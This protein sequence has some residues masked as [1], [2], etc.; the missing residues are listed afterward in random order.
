MSATVAKMAVRWELMRDKTTVDEQGNV[1]PLLDANGEP[2]QE[3][4]AIPDGLDQRLAAVRGLHEDDVAY[5]FQKIVDAT[6]QPKTAS[7][8]QNFTTAATAP[9]Q[10]ISVAENVSPKG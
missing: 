10:A 8:Q 6:P 1:I 7:A 2:M 9:S 5:I 4:F 3:P